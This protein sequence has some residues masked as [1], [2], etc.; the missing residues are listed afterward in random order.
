MDELLERLLTPLAEPHCQAVRQRWQRRSPEDAEYSSELDSLAAAL[1]DYPEVY[2]P[3]WWL[4]P[5]LSRWWLCLRVDWK[6]V[7]EVEWQVQAISHTLGL[8]EP[9]FVSQVAHQSGVCV[10]MVLIAAAAWLR[11]RGYELLEIDTGGDEYLAFPVRL[12]L[13]REA[14]QATHTLSLCTHLI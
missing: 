12:S 3:E 4:N 9:P 1:Q 2:P 11:L 13:L 8:R 14:F 6:A 10:P 5:V 7:D